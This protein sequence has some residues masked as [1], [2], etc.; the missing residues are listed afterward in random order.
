MIKNHT[1]TVRLNDIEFNG[2]SEVSEKMGISKSEVVRRMFW[3]VR[4]LF[5][6]KVLLKEALLNIDDIDSDM[7]LSAALRNIPE[8][9]I[10][11][12]EKKDE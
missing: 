3:T 10:D 8:L 7:P 11:M 6:D 12:I 2:I 9:L 4:V 5:S 1:L